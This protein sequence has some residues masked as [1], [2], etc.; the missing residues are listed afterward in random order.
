MESKE[1]LKHK[2]HALFKKIA[3]DVSKIKEDAA[4]EGK[5]SIQIGI[6]A[7]M[8]EQDMNRFAEISTVIEDG[9][10]AE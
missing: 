4:R 10:H 3:G 1:I 8:I 6:D 7:L 2:R 9:E 5:A